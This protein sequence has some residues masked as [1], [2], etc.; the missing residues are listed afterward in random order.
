VKADPCP[1]TLKALEKLFGASHVRLVRTTA[2]NN[3]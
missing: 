2:A 1:E 3:D